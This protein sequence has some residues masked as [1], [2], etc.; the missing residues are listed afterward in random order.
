MIDFL[1]K[2]KLHITRVW[3]FITMPVQISTYLFA[4]YAAVKLSGDVWLFYTIPFLLAFSIGIWIIDTR[5]LFTAEM[6]Y[7]QSRNPTFLL[8]CKNAKEANERLMRIED[9]LEIEQNKDELRK[10]L[11]K[12][13]DVVGIPSTQC[14]GMKQRSL[15]CHEVNR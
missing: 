10:D 3:S 12:V 7:T 5:S 6:E 15:V 4:T 14:R 2:T 13:K 11:S 1:A 9:R 8:L